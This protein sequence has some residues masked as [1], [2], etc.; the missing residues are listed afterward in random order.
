MVSYWHDLRLYG[1]GNVSYDKPPPGVEVSFVAGATIDDPKLALP[2]GITNLGLLPMETFFS[3]ISR[4]RVLVGIS[5]PFHSPSPYDAL[6]FGVPFI[7]PVIDWDRRHP[8]NRAKWRVQQVGLR[9]LEPPYVYHVKR[10]DVEGFWKAIQHAIERPID[11]S[12]LIFVFPIRSLM[13]VSRYIPPHMTL[14]QLKQRVGSIIERDWKSE[15]ENVLTQMK[16]DGQNP[17]RAQTCLPKIASVT[18]FIRQTFVL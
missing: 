10:G 14:E 6:C 16:V 15:A 11:R 9:M 7:N 18:D 5:Q 3:E 8:E 12:V 17:V 4:S 1:W 13:T 2:G